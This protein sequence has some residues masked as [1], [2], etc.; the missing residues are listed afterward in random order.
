LV[1]EAPE[2][3]QANELQSIIDQRMQP[4]NQLLSR[5][6]QQQQLSQRQVQESANQ[7]VANF[8]GEFLSDVRND[9]AD[10]IDMAAARGQD[11]TLQ[12]A[13]DKAVVLRPDLQQIISERKKNEELTGKRS[14]INRKLNAASSVAGTRGGIASGSAD[15][16]RGAIE[17]AWDAGQ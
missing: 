9:M 8:K 11:I 13:Y 5:I 1:G 17:D 12:E 2:N 7:E 10:L 6:E 3:S 4:V 16:L 14:N 15:S